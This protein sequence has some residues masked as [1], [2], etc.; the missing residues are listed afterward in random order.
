MTK[1]ADV[2]AL[3]VLTLVLLA[4]QISALCTSPT[5]ANKSEGAPF[6][7]S[8]MAD[9]RIQTACTTA[10]EE[11]IVVPW[12][13]GTITRVIPHQSNQKVMSVVCFVGTPAKTD[14]QT[15]GEAKTT[16]NSSVMSHSGDINTVVSIN[17]PVSTTPLAVAVHYVV[18]PGVVEFSACHSDVA[19]FA[20]MTVQ[21]GRAV[22]LTRWAM[23]GLS[24]KQIQLA[25][26][27]FSLASNVEGGIVDVTLYKPADFSIG[28][29]ENYNNNVASQVTGN[30]SD[31][32]PSEIVMFLRIWKASTVS[33]CTMLRD[34]LSEQAILEEGK[35]SRPDIGVTIVILIVVVVVVSIGTGV[36]LWWRRSKNNDDEEGSQIGIDLPQSLQHFVY[37]TGDEVSS[38]KWQQW[39][40]F[41][42]S[43]H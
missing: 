9:V 11:T 33:P 25:T 37:D 14:N 17:S 32:H 16:V 8:I 4:S 13:T 2:K 43:R 35:T 26:T 3:L 7:C 6:W 19:D 15:P 29:S 40:S 24:T 12:S 31:M 28:N 1:A 20:N 5:N 27:R 30:T 41:E 36:W 23:G 22:M 42:A 38:Q 39:T 10:V 21:A 18:V 34:C